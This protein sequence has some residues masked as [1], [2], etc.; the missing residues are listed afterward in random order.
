M[1]AAQWIGCALALW[2]AAGPAAARA[3][4]AADYRG[5]ASVDPAAAAL[6]E[7]VTYRGRAIL[8]PVHGRVRWLPPDSSAAVSWGPLRAR[9]AHTDTRYT[10]KKA[11][12]PAGIVPG[13]D[14]LIVE[15]TV[16]AFRTG[17]VR[18]PGLRFEE[19][20]GRGPVVRTLPMV[21]L[22]IT[23]VLAANDTNP[24]LHPPRGPLGAPWWERVPWR[25]VLLVAAVIATIVWL[26][27]VLRR[28]RKPVAPVV[29][30]V[31]VDPVARALSELAALRRR[32]LPARGEFDAHAF[33][34]SRILR[35][36]LEAVRTRSRPGDT[37][38]ELLERL[39][40]FGLAA[41]EHGRLAALLQHWDL[42]KFARAGSS[43]ADAQ[44]AEAAVEALVKRPLV[45]TV[46]EA[47]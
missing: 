15:T 31:G 19:Q 5:R 22:A 10:R 17:L 40:A 30:P 6:G 35:H 32:G 26:V 18:I 39:A 16:Q 20:T 42:V 45:R 23:S 4:E 41:E 29:T 9:I 7:R 43:T 8:P 27:V 14:T 25:W 1:S 46:A 38:P 24:Q 13:A 36:Y 21:P 37:T 12:D 11:S 47:A 2:V 33:E 3:Q 44:A 28:R 34:L